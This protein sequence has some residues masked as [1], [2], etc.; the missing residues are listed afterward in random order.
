MINTV[1]FPGLFEKVFTLDRVAFTLFGNDIMWYG[2]IIAFGFALAGI[3]ACIHAKDYGQ[4][5]DT[6]LDLLIWCLPIAII[7][8]R[9]YFVLHRWGYYSQN[10]SEILSIREGGLGFYGGF[11]AAILTGI[12]VCKKKKKNVLS[13][14]DIAALGFILAQSIG[15]W[16]NFI[17][18]EA[19]GSLTTMPWG[20]S[21]NG[22][23]PVHPT[24]F[25]ESLWNM[26][27]FIILHFYSKKRKFD[28]EIFLLY[29]AWY[30]FGRMFI[31]GL[32]TDSLYILST[33]IRVSQVVAALSFII[34]FGLWI[35]FTTTKKYKPRN[36]ERK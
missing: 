21:I 9:A 2:V 31:E 25:Y 13:T 27:G 11:A 29:M 26:I 28:G 23:A 15:R 12:I 19:F 8:A 1:S 16:G 14:L 7:G 6:I 32:R 34:C 35:Y 5:I 22:G 4:D 17:N 10:L 24:F 20:M 18:C 3:Y 33:S 36:T 30:G